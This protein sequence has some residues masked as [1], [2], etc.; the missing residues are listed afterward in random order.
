MS[1]CQTVQHNA[2]H[3]SGGRSAPTLCG[4]LATAAPGAPAEGSA[5]PPVQGQPGG[6]S[7]LPT[8]DS[9][10]SGTESAVRAGRHPGTLHP[11]GKSSGGR[12]GTIGGLRRISFWAFAR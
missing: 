5:S 9:L 8:P 10:Q 2:D 6:V 12:R 7:M 4:L 11:A 1:P 3:A